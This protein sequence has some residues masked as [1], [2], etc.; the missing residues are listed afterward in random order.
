MIW[1]KRLCSHFPNVQSELPPVVTCWN[2]LLLLQFM[3]IENVGKKVLLFRGYMGMSATLILLTITLYFQVS[4]FR[5]CGWGTAYFSD[6]NMASDEWQP[7]MSLLFSPL[8]SQVSWLPY[9]SMGLIFIFIFF[10]SSG[11]GVCLISD[12]SHLRRIFSIS[13]AITSHCSL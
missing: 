5:P 11:P 2:C 3:I 9:C 1:V 10:F 8:Q 13:T 12:R 6:S 7:L 4:H